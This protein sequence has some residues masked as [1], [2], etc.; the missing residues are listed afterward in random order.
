MHTIE[1][2]N[3]QEVIRLSIEDAT[4][5]RLVLR[6]KSE[7][8]CVTTDAYRA[9]G[10]ALSQAFHQLDGKATLMDLSQRVYVTVSFHRAGVDIASMIRDQEYVIRTDQSFMTDAVRQ[11]GLWD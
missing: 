3:E 5:D 9:F 1:F 7:R 2:R 10:I 11:I 4:R 6:M 8:F